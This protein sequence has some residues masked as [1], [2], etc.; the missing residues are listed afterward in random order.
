MLPV[1]Y[2]FALEKK[3][4]RFWASLLRPEWRKSC[5]LWE[6]LFNLQ[7]FWNFQTPLK[8]CWQLLDSSH[9]QTQVALRNNAAFAQYP[10]RMQRKIVEVGSYEKW[11]IAVMLCMLP[12]TADIS[13]TFM[14]HWSLIIPCRFD[15]KRVIVRQGH[16]ANAFYFIL[17]GSGNHILPASLTEFGLIIAFALQWLSWSLIL[18]QKSPSQLLTCTREWHLV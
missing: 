10:V 11:V 14:D 6:Y 18:K 16:P 12:D 1:L 13:I 15:A 7:N 8:F 3:S 9:V 4:R 5:I 2:S 17:S